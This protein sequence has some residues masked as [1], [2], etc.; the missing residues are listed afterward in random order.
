MPT[1]PDWVWLLNND[2]AFP[3]ET[4]NRLLEIARS[5]ALFMMSPYLYDYSNHEK[6]QFPGGVFFAPLVSCQFISGENRP[7]PCQGKS[8]LT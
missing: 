8:K 4:L 3:P 5:R 1:N 6:L 2:T 7:H